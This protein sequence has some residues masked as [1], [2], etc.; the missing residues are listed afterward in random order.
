MHS[1]FL[2]YAFF[3]GKVVPFE[4][5]KISVATLALQYGLGVFGGVRGYLNHDQSCINIFRLPEHM[6]RFSRSANLLKI[7]LASDAAGLAEIMVELT[8]KNA[9]SGDV[10][11]RPFA[12]KSDLSLGPS[13]SHPGG[14]FT[15][16]ML[17]LG[18][19][20]GASQ[21]LN[22]M[23]SS[24]VRPNDNSIPARG[25]IAGA[26]VNSSIAK[27][28]AT[29]NGYDD[30]IMLNNHGKVGEGSAANL[31]MVRD[32]VLITPSINADILE[33]I[34]RSSLMQL[35]KDLGIPVQERN[36]DRS[37]LYI[38]DELFLCGTGAQISPAAS[39]DKRPI[40]DP[41]RPITT[42]LYNLFFD[43]VRGK[44]PDYASWLTSIPVAVST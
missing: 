12:Y 16:Y 13:L 5:A 18:N 34:T 40:G 14:G 6:T 36:I 29:T 41:A 8:R 33:G 38:C 7:T 17:P 11:Y 43:I 28:E 3:E 25:K 39:V 35:A 27:D 32:G 44:N 24:W 20:F 22:L 15:V 30:A 26:Y 4:D 31:F 21:A 9:P 2:P 42:R 23:V 10:Y 1:S 37:E 19:Y